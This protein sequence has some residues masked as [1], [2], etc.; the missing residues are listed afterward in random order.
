MSSVPLPPFQQSNYALSYQQSSFS[1]RKLIYLFI[2]PS[3]PPPCK[4]QKVKTLFLFSIFLACLRN[5]NIPLSK[6]N[7]F[8]NVES[9]QWIIIRLSREKVYSK[10]LFQLSMLFIHIE[11]MRMMFLFFSLDT[12]RWISKYLHNED[13][14]WNE[15]NHHVMIRTSLIQLFRDYQSYL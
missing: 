13:P 1:F 15:F 5:L 12:Y 14:P 4:K 6:L 3:S 7:D 8:D 11:R 10:L 9:S 2:P